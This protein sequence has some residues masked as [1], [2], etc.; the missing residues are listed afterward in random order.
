MHVLP[1]DL[2]D[3]GR[4]LYIKGGDMVNLCMIIESAGRIAH[5]AK[6]RMLIWTSR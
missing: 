4:N 3:V 6:A 5:N 2:H 1:T